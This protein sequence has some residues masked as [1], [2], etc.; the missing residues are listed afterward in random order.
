MTGY[1]WH[2]RLVA[3]LIDRWRDRLAT[4]ERDAH[5]SEVD[6]AALDHGEWRRRWGAT[7]EEN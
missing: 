2:Y 6:V 1:L 5:E 7:A 4:V 3:T